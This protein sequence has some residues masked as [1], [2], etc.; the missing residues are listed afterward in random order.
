MEKEYSNITYSL[1]VCRNPRVRK[2]NQVWDLELKQIN[3]EK[4]SGLAKAYK[5]RKASVEKLINH[6]SKRFTYIRRK[7]YEIVK[8]FHPQRMAA[9]RHKA[10]GSD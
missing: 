2:I 8:S 1:Y 3:P 5:F 6:T 9:N 4:I 7:E 10:V